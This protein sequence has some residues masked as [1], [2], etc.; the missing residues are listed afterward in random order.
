MTFAGH[1]IVGGPNVTLTGT[2]QSIYEQL[3]EINPSYNPWA[4]PKYR[5]QMARKGFTQDN[6]A[7]ALSGPQR[8]ANTLKKRD[9]VIFGPFSPMDVLCFLT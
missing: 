3:L 1:A 9:G 2:A 8:G 5:E 4:F 7:D 6:F